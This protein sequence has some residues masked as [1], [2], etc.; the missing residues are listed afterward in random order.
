M[1]LCAV[2]P[3]R[4]APAAFQMF[5]DKPSWEGAVSTYTA[6]TF[7]DL[8]GP[9]HVTNQYAHLGVTF[10]NGDDVVWFS[11][12][13][14][15]Q[16]GWG[17]DANANCHLKFDFDIYAIGVWHPGNMA[18]KLYNDGQ[19]VF[20]FPFF[21]GGGTNWFGGVVGTVPFDE[22]IIY[23]FFD[24]QINIDDIYFAAIPAP[25]VWLAMVG[26]LMVGGRRRR[27]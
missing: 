13:L 4:V 22:V 5:F 8:G 15:P 24:P 18:L 17:I 3:T 23:D 27:A 2:L 26:G 11:D 14:Y 20:S 10:L 19:L 7:A 9:T 6:L 1:A 12:Y 16:D 25:S 21:P